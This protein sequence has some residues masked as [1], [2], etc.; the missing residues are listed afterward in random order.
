VIYILYRKRANEFMLIENEN[1]KLKHELATTRVKLRNTS[2][3][4][5]LLDSNLNK[6]SFASRILAFSD[7]K[8]NS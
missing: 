2:K 6:C 1:K 8:N 4:N 3:D 5:R 7:T